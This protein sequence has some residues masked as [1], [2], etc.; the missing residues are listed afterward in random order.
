MI[1]VLPIFV[2]A[3]LVSYYSNDYSCEYFT[4]KSNTKFH[5]IIFKKDK[6]KFGVSN[7]NSGNFNFYVNSNFFGTN[8]D[9][10]G[11]VVI[12]GKRT[13]SHVNKG[14]SFIVKDGKPNIVFGEV[15]KCEYESQSIIWVIK[16]GKKNNGMLKQP[17]AKK[18]VMR[19]L[20]GKNKK[21]E[22]V[23]IHSNQYVLVT[24]SEIVNIAIENGVTDAII[25][26]SGSS[27]DLMLTNGSFSHSVKSVPS[28]FKDLVGIK[29]PPV[30]I[31]GSF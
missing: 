25:L 22:I 14:G 30:Y 18:Q 3:K 26:D 5:V 19:L 20:M 27:V 28:G 1:L 17:H 23:V 6:V 8:G 11:G 12:N 13:S 15:G 24:M 4:I 7:N 31:T 21:G 9:A 29:E 2:C 16:D 10:I